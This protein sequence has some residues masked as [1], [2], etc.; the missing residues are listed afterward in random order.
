VFVGDT[1]AKGF[2]DLVLVRPPELI[3]VEVKRE[4]GRTTVEQDEWLADLAAA[5]VEVYV[6]RPSTWALLA[7]RLNHRPGRVGQSGLT[8]RS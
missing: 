6:A 1:D 8:E 7:A 2:P 5:G 4:L 3:A